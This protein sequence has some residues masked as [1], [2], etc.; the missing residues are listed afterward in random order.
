MWSCGGTGL[1]PFG[2]VHDVV[3]VLL[4]GVGELGGEHHQ[5]GDFAAE[6]GDLVGADVGPFQELAVAELRRPTSR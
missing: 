4:G 1:A 2:Q 5:P 3:A 6:A